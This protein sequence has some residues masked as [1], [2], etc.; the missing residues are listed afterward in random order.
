MA[1]VVIVIPVYNERESSGR[2]IESLSKTF[3]RIPDHKMLALYVD[4][5][6]PDGTADVIRSKQTRFP[7]LHL[8]VESKKTGI[9]GAYAN[10]MAYAMAKLHADYL[11]EM[12]GDFQHRPEDLISLVAQI[13]N[14]YDYI[15]GSRYIKGGSIPKEWG[16]NRVFLS[17][18]GNLVARILFIMPKLH[19]VTGG[20]R[21]S[22]VKGF[23]DKFDFATL[24]SRSFAYKLHLFYFMV[25][26]GAKTIEVPIQFDHRGSGESKL[27][28]NEIPDMLKV[29]F[30]LQAKNPKILRFVKFGITGALGLLWQT[31]TFQLLAFSFQLTTPKV[32]TL[33]G[34]EIAVISNFILN[35]AWTFR[36]HSVQG[37][38]LVG[39]F[40]QFNLS[41]VIPLTIQTGIVK[42]GE[43]VAHGNNLVIWGFFA[44]ALILVI[45]TNYLIYNIFIWKTIPLKLPSRPKL[46]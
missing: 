36:E 1:R 40:I 12:D 4:G 6:S 8:V 46:K 44:S 24:A 25:T 23:M 21:I 20:F 19:D 29:I 43:V 31:I 42:I 26:S 10:G 14:G 30:T 34:G 35:N 27:I 13:N 38:K 7:W 3:A 18:V 39:K 15:V 11:V 32:A 17:V 2:F 37:K 28:K 5:N 45:I 9:G 33:I 16:I 22:R 41:G